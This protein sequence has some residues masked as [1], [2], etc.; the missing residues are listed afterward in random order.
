MKRKEW[1][2]YQERK[3][4]VPWAV[5]VDAV[6]DGRKVTATFEVFAEWIN[7]KSKRMV[8]QDVPIT[9]GASSFLLAFHRLADSRGH[10]LTD[11]DEMQVK[12]E[13][14]ML[15]ESFK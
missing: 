3:E 15:K 14:K 1:W 7:N 13:I 11:A 9:N 2:I 10:P 6:K 12:Y 8:F 4:E 5:H